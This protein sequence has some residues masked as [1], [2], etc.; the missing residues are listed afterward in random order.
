MRWDKCR[1]GPLTRN[2]GCDFY[3]AMDNV[4]EGAAWPAAQNMGLTLGLPE[5]TGL[6]LTGTNP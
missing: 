5:E 3:S 4:L 2:E 1:L 6:L